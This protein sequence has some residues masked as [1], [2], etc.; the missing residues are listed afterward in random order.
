VD[1][2][3]AAI[4]KR[5][6]AEIDQLDGRG[7]A[8]AARS[9][10]MAG[11]VMAVAVPVIAVGGVA[12]VAVRQA[13]G[14]STV[15]TISSQPGV[16]VN[17]PQATGSAETTVPAA[18]S[19]GDTQAKPVGWQ[20]IA[21]VALGEGPRL[22]SQQGQLIVASASRSATANK[23]VM[24]WF[25]PGQSG[26]ATRIELD[27]P[28]PVPVNHASYANGDA[29][30]LSSGTVVH[31]ESDQTF[32]TATP[33][34]TGRGGP[35]RLA[36]TDD[37]I[38]VDLASLSRYDNMTKSWT[39]I[40]GPP[41]QSLGEVATAGGP[42][43][44]IIAGIGAPTLR[45]SPAGDQ[46]SSHIPVGPS[47]T[48]GGSAAIYRGEA[49]ILLAETGY[50]ASFD[51]PSSTWTTFDDAAEFVAPAEGY[52]PCQPQAVETTMPAFV[53]CGRLIVYD[54]Q[55]WSTLRG[56]DQQWVFDSV[57]VDDTIYTLECNKPSPGGECEGTITGLKV[58]TPEA[59]APPQTP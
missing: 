3:D 46:W 24:D 38:L 19:D 11:L 29:L 33:G 47:Q 14:P 9:R 56:Q 16:A 35:M 26:S 5:I 39:A 48:Q 42:T 50:A 41:S 49:T 37:G 32:I 27:D 55:Q 13:N 52:P 7:V 4:R 1:D 12:F 43:D 23:L 20:V 15:D 8:P 6:Q 31:I 44:I 51:W 22:I 59:G 18:T 54:G 58:T 10:R 21:R 45:Y 2:I 36:A 34:A 40:G 57:Q 28:N 30:L 53:V 17:P 25:T